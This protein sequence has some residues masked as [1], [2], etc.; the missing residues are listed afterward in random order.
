VSPGSNTDDEKKREDRF[1]FASLREY[2]PY[3]TLGF[4]LAAAVVVFSLIGAWLDSRWDTSPWLLLCGLL[5][6]S[7]GG[8]VKFFKTISDLERHDKERRED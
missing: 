7:V 2:S 3:L 1:G 6:G 8:F 4:Q 5:L